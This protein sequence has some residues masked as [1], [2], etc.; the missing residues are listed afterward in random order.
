MFF[1]AYVGRSFTD[2]NDLS[3]AQAVSGATVVAING[4][5]MVPVSQVKVPDLPLF[6]EGLLRLTV[7]IALVLLVAIPSYF[8]YVIWQ[9]TH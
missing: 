5:V 1:R 7:T 4:G 9:L 2:H 3:E 8:V 6:L